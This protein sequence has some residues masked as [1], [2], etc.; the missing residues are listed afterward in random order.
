MASAPFTKMVATADTR[1]VFIDHS[2]TFL[3]ERGFDGLDLDWEYPAR[4]GSPSGDKQRFV[5]LLKELQ[6]AYVIEGAQTGRDR[7]L[8]TAAVAAGQGNIDGVYD[9]PRLDQ[10]LDFVNIMSYDLRGAWDTVTGHQAPL[11]DWTTLNVEWAVNYWVSL[12]LRPSK[13]VV[14]LPT[15]GRSWTLA[16]PDTDTGL[17]AR[18]AWGGGTAGQ[19]TRERG[20]LAFYEICEYLQDPATVMTRVDTMGDVPFLVKGNQW[21]GYDD[22][23][24][25][26]A[27]VEFA[28]AYRHNNFPSSVGLG[29][30]MVWSLGMDDFTGQACGLGRYPLMNTIK[31]TCGA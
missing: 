6:T 24:S 22:T 20:F 30:V 15:Y 16:S 31:R 7:L 25:I 3:R 18:A 19:Y 9:V 5:E 27:K 10:Y 8:L 23:V 26:A 12:G 2:I 17:G 13:L 1:K 29:G 4:R 14:G 28:K 21:V 11:R